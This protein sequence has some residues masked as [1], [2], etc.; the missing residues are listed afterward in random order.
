M[1][2]LLLLFSTLWEKIKLKVKDPKT[3]YLKP[4]TKQNVPVLYIT[5]ANRRNLMLRLYSTA[6]AY[7]T[8]HCKL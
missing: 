8:H 5:K 1:R 4:D 6:C 2:N 7:K 3:F